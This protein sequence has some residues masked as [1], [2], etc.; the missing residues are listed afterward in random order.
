MHENTIRIPRGR[1]EQPNLPAAKASAIRFSLKSENQDP[2]QAGAVAEVAPGSC[3]AKSVGRWK[4]ILDLSLV[5]LSSPVWLPLIVVIA[6][7]VALVSP[8]PVFFRQRR[9]GLRRR[10]FQIFKFRTMKV[11]VSTAPHDRHVAALM[12]SDS[13]LVKLD[14]IGDPR[15]IP[16]GRF[17]RAAGLDELPQ[18]INVLRG[19]MSLVGPRPCTVN[20]FGR[21]SA[22]QQNRT[23]ALPGLTGYWQIN[24]KNKTT[25]SEMIAMDLFYVDNVSLRLD[26]RILLRTIPAVCQQVRETRKVLAPPIAERA[27]ALIR[28]EHQ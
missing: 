22:W 28:S 19:E 7:W 4:R 21:Y 23:N 26:V 20:E 10:H 3:S 8:G 9:V 15:L 17:I 25:F 6:A 5:C 2:A 16:G 24:G 14:E 18:I 11:A 1:R 27:P 13:P 12:E